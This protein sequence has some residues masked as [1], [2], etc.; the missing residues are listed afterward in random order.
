MYSDKIRTRSGYSISIKLLIRLNAYLAA[1]S[2]Q[3]IVLLHVV[4]L[5]KIGN[6]T[7]YLTAITPISSWESTASES[8]F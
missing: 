1:R 8:F 7:E 3:K 4:N 2:L 5:T 6:L